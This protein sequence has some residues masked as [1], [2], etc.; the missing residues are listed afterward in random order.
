MA[1]RWTLN[2]GLGSNS[3]RATIWSMVA[4]GRYGIDNITGLDAALS[5]REPVRAFIELPGTS[6]PARLKS[7]QLRRAQAILQNLILERVKQ[8][9]TAGVPLPA[10]TADQLP[11]NASRVVPLAADHMQ[12]ATLDRI[13]RQADVGTAARH[14]RGDRHTTLHPGAGNPLGFVRQMPRVQNLV[15]DPRREGLSYRLIGRNLGLSKNTVM[16]IVKRAD[17]TA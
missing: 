4:G 9:I 3:R 6:A 15:L 10:T 1:C 12:S 11:V 5:P 13:A 7:P 17:A 14:V 16:N 2:V 8:P